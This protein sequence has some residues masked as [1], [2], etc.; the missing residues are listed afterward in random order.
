[1]E[2]VA[3]YCIL[4]Q[5]FFIIFFNFRNLVE[6]LFIFFLYIF[7]LNALTHLHPEKLFF[8]ACLQ[9][10]CFVLHILTFDERKS[11]TML[12][13]YN[14]LS[15]VGQMM[16]EKPFWLHMKKAFIS[17]VNFNEM[18]KYRSSIIKKSQK[19][20]TIIVNDNIK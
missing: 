15:F 18:I 4:L 17:N 14:L 1:M 2:R 3:F 19:N 11:E 12:H 8:I 7:L 10:N 9:K 16:L 13:K 20:Y 6:E 5:F